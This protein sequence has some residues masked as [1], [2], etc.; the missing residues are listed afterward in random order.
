MATGVVVDILN[1]VHPVGSIY[2]STESTSPAS[3]F[4]GGWLQITDRFLLGAGSS[5]N[6]G[7][8]G[9]EA[10]HTLTEAEMPSHRHGAIFNISGGGDFFQINGA[11][12][13]SDSSAYANTGYAGGGQA[14]NNMPPYFAVYMWRRVS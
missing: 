2:M 12:R 6:V 14:H 4:G 7:D 1:V 9:G 11:N 3:L 8:V 10:A 13:T 5:Y